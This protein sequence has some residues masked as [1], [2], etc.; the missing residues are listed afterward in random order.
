MQGLTEIAVVIPTHN[1][2]DLVTEAVDSVLAQTEAA[3]EIIVVDDGS[4]D[5]TRD[6]LRRYS[7]DIKYVYQ[8]NRGLSAARNRG[9]AECQAEW[10]AFLDADDLWMP[11]KLKEQLPLI[12]AAPDDVM[13]IHSRSLIMGPNYQV[14]SPLPPRKG[15]LLL[16]DLAKRNHV[17]VLTAV[18]RTDIILELGGFDENLTAL[19]DWDL[20]LRIAAAGY[21]FRYSPQVLATYRVSLGAMHM[22]AEKME[23]NA[24]RVLGN[25][26]STPGLPPMVSSLS[27]T[28]H[29]LFYLG[30]SRTFAFQQDR[31]SALE[32]ASKALRCKPG[33][34]LSGSFLGSILRIA[35]PRFIYD[36]FR[37][38]NRRRLTKDARGL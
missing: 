29:A 26:F 19:E 25:F 27:T 7:S 14:L 17:A 15:E 20:W 36:L 30:L 35:L 10:V 16:Q 3:S 4:T 23:Q 22:D 9:I 33:I 5:D 18:V 38:V 37:M 11:H 2:A 1:H 8:P 32:Y 24:R 12:E 13:C 31:K 34:A 28:A 21:R 6:K